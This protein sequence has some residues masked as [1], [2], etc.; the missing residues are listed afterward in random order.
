MLCRPRFQQRNGR[1]AGEPADSH[2]G[3]GRTRTLYVV[4]RKAVFRGCS[5]AFADSCL[6][7]GDC[8]GAHRD[9]QTRQ[10]TCAGEPLPWLGPKGT[11]RRQGEGV[12]SG[13][14]LGEA[15]GPV[16]REEDHRAFAVSHAVGAMLPWVTGVYAMCVVCCTCGCHCLGARAQIKRTGGFSDSDSDNDDDLL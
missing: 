3:H 13:G 4:C 12:V 10:G 8:S 16:R 1:A 2:H 14:D 7:G 5:V 15:G 6:R 9:R 11:T